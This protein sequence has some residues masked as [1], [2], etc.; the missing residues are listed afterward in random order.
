[1][2]ADELNPT[3]AAP[4]YQDI[5]DKRRPGTSNDWRRDLEIQKIQRKA[6]GV[7]YSP[8]HRRVEHR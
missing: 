2:G 6:S 4:L 7:K 3:P 1:M 8:K 5:S